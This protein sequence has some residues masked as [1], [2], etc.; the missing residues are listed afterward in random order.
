[1]LR[2]MEGGCEASG[3]LVTVFERSASISDEDEFWE[4]LR[5]ELCCE[6]SKPKPKSSLP[7][8]RRPTSFIRAPRSTAP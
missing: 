5:E 8:S 6:L 3:G 1:M 7:K 4:E 2:G